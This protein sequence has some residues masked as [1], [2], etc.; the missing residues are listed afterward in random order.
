LVVGGRGRHLP[1]CSQPRVCL[2]QAPENHPSIHPRAPHLQMHEPGRA[3]LAAVRPV[4][5]ARHEVHAK[6]AL[7]GLDALV[8]LAAVGGWGGVWG[9]VETVGRVACIIRAMA[10]SERESAPSKNAEQERAL[11]LRG[12]GSP[13]CRA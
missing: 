11:T 13:L 10:V 3:D 2:E 7:G 1:A 5:A 4:A 6:L 12:R 8:G 9:A